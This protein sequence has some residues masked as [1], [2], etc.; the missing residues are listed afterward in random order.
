MP[1]HIIN[2]TTE[3]YKMH[4]RAKLVHVHHREQRRLEDGSSQAIKVEA[5]AASMSENDFEARNTNSSN[6]PATAISLVFPRPWISSEKVEEILL[7]SIFW[8][9]SLD[10][11]DERIKTPSHQAASKVRKHPH[12]PSCAR[13]WLTFTLAGI[14]MSARFTSATRLDIPATT[15][16]A[17]HP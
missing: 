3:M 17:G 6:N 4:T 15:L 10:S 8:T 1:A 7:S 12:R 5:P 9:E 11:L 2:S 14:V 13:A 16:A